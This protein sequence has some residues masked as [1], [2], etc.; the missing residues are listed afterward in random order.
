MLVVTDGGAADASGR[1]Q[2]EGMHVI[3][4]G[5]AVAAAFAA[6]ALSGCSGG[7]DTNGLETKSAAEVQQEA[8]AALKAAKSVH[9]MVKDGNDG[10]AV[11]ADLRIQGGSS[12]GSL[13]LEGIRYEVIKV[14]A[15]FYLN[16]DRRG[17]AQL[18]LPAAI[19]RRDADQ[20]LKLG[21]QHV[22]SLQGFTLDD[23]AADLTK[24]ESPLE[25]KVEQGTLDG[26][27]VVVISHQNGSRLYVAN[28]G[29]A[30]PLR[31][32]SKGAEPGQINFLEYG[33]DFHITAPPNYFDI[34]ELGAESGGLSAEELVWLESI[35]ALRK[36][37]DREFEHAGSEYE[38]S[39]I[40]S[41]AES[42]RSCSRELDRLGAA[43]DQ[44]Q[45][46]YELV[47]KACQQYDKGAECFSAVGKI[48]NEAPGA[49]AKANAL[50]DCGFAAHDKGS[51]L[52]ADAE[53]QGFKNAATS[54]TTGVE[55][56]A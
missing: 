32:D 18:G 26:R 44:L 50:F 41:L 31:L 51:R 55:Q 13:T 5:L 38:E 56:A 46:A 49:E 22:T 54:G 42:M 47:K 17:L 16:G 19:L 9:V 4:R 14:G 1:A 37:I 23:L 24:F 12:S 7:A 45:R 34:S 10:K 8:A 39:E 36:K 25:P 27:K 6:V 11:S 48:W 15:D 20:W 30:Y 21:T 43:G 28:T 53:T 40:A 29:I 2:G 33:A 35:G 3:S 52:L